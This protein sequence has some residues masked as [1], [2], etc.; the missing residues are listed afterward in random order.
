[1]AAGAISL[2]LSFDDGF[3][4]QPRMGSCG[5]ELYAAMAPVAGDDHL[6]GWALAHLCEAIGRMRQAVSDIVR[7][8]D[9]GPGWVRATDIDLL[10]G[11]DS[12]ID[13]EIDMVPFFA[14]LVGVRLAPEL[15]DDDRIEAIRQRNGFWRGRPAAIVSYAE[16]FTDGGGVVLRQRYDPRLGFG[17]DAPYCGRVV[18]KRSR[19]KPGV[20]EDD[21][22]RR[23]LDR[24]PAGLI[25]D[26]VIT[27]ARDYDDVADTFRTYD[28]VAAGTT[29]Y[30]D[31]LGG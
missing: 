12:E 8:S 10:P 2:T 13:S 31:L 21:L 23:I 26:V 29:S 9:V 22:R 20:V 30:D 24:I 25:Y 15:S 18:I 28:G 6:Y 16:R 14:Q 17:V 27:D 5:A 19:L 7:D 1:M 4:D 3:A 11:A